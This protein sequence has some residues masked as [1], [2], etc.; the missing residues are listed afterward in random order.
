MAVLDFGE[1]K[2]LEFKVSHSVVLCKVAD[3]QRP[4]PKVALGQMM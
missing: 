3:Q 4:V 2:K 1:E